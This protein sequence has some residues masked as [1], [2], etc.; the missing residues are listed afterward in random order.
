MRQFHNIE[1]VWK[2]ID[3]SKTIYWANKAYK[4]TVES[5]ALDW[6]QEN[7]YSIPF[8]NKDGLCLRVTCI[9]NYFGSLLCE[10]DLGSLFVESEG[11]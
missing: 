8:S 7:G 4:L 6:R 1:Q 2:A 11:G 5:S 10:D 3:E 9:S